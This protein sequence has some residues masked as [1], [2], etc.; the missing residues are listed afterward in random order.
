MAKREKDEGDLVG[1]WANKK[2]NPLEIKWMCSP[3]KILGVHFSYD[4]KNNDLNFNVILRKLQTRLDK[5]RA[6][7]LTLFGGAL[8]I[9]SLGL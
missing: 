6:R 9:K 3:V 8:I 1:K 7:D 5:W 4:E 2:S